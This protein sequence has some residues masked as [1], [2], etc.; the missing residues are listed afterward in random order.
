MSSEALLRL[1]KFTK[2][3]PV[4]FNGTPSKDPQDYLDRCHEVL[5]NM[6][7]GESNKVDFAIS[8]LC[9]EKFI[10]I[11]LRE[12]YHRRF[13]HLQQG[14]M[15]IT[16]YETRFVD[17]A[18]YAIVLLP[19]EKERIRRFIDGL[20]YTARLQ[21]DKE[22]GIDISFHTAVNIARW[23]ELVHARERGPVSDKRPRHS[24]NFRGT[25][26]GGRGTYGM[27]HPSRPFYSALQ[28]SYGASG[29]HG[30]IMPYSGQPTFSAHPAPISAPPLQSHYSSYPARS[31]QLQVQQPRYCP[32]LSSNRSQQDSCAIIP[33][34]I[35]LALAQPAR[36]RGQTT[37][38]GGQVVRGIVP[39]CH[40]DA[41]VLFDL[42]STY[43][44]VSFYFATYLVVPRGSLIASLCVS[45]PVRDSVVVN[46][47]YHSYVVTIWSFETSVDFLLLDIVDFN[48]ILGMDWLLPYHTILDC[49]AKMVT[50]AMPG[51]PRIEWKGTP[52]HSTSKIVS[53]VKARR[54]V[55]KG[56]LAY[57]AYIRD[58][59]EEHPYMDSVPVV[60]EFPDIFPID[61]PGMPPDRDIDFCIDSA[62]GTQPISIPPYRMAPSELKELKEQ[63]Q[64][65]LDQGFIRPSVSPWG[66]PVLFVK[67]KDGY[68][69][70]I[71]YVFNSKCIELAYLQ[72]AS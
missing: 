28:V 43:S 57:L 17:L 60:C 42:G 29:S 59:S 36:G 23:I 49:H 20:T 38:G 4:H 33:A 69:L 46:H 26:S 37:R 53:Y 62:P 27:G 9:L 63:L 5:R 45:T 13:E 21:V 2:I 32:R 34:P 65:L 72:V 24:G 18:R 61:L 40:R 58:P 71:I 6:E 64:D 12:E 7:I 70:P 22:V 68:N 51:L 10:P 48:V 55:E 30:P 31:V 54:M 1:N 41:S 67:K 3:F 50:L 44:Y 25:S 8:Q 47:V 14:S 52:G 19:T 66:A 39:V 11:T 15:T 16:Q 35:A 56:C